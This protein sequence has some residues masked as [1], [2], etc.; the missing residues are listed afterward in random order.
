MPSCGSV[1][2]TV[3]IGV[4]FEPA[5]FR[6]RHARA[7]PAAS[8]TGHERLVPQ[9][10][11]ALRVVE[12]RRRADAPGK[13]I[14]VLTSV[15]AKTGKLRKI[16]LMR[17]EHDG[18]YA[19]VASLGGAARNPVLVPQPQEEPARR[20][21]GWLRPSATTWRNE[22]FGD[23]EGPLVGARGRGLARLRDVPEEDRRA[24]SRSFVLTA[25]DDGRRDSPSLYISSNRRGSIGRRCRRASRSRC[26]ESAA[27]EVL[28]GDREIGFAE[29]G[30]LT[31][32]DRPRS[33]P[34]RPR[35]SLR[36]RRPEARPHELDRALR[37][38]PAHHQR[39]G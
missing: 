38:A 13:P 2:P 37:L 28:I 15:G 21:A 11:R 7:D 1:H 25:I 14:I 29:V 26:S 35:S 33:A 19:V 39:Q 22:V 5:A 34:D 16:A 4:I 8:R 30:R 24:R 20:A 12:R 18:D 17:V 10:D 6:I 36:D 3:G 9:A 32:G 27:F 23:G 31:L